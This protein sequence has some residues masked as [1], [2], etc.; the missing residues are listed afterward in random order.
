[1]SPSG[2]SAL[3]RLAVVDRLEAGPMKVEGDRIAATYRLGDDR[4]ELAY[5]YVASIHGLSVELHYALARP[6]VAYADLDG[7]LDLIEDPGGGRGHSSQ[8]Q[9]VSHGGNG[10]GFELR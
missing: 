8:R 2:A 7:H 5:R 6:N 1:M 9:A 4:F 10:L 3:S